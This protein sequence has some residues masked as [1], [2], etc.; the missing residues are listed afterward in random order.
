MI[1]GL[2]DAD[3][4]A[5]GAAG[6]AGAGGDGGAAGGEGGAGAGE[7]GKGTKGDAPTTPTR[8]AFLQKLDKIRESD[9]GAIAGGK[10][11]DDDDEEEL[12]EDAVIDQDEELDDDDDAGAGA[13]DDDDAPEPI[14]READG[15]EWIVDE[16]GQDGHWELDGTA[17]EGAPPKDW[18]PTPAPKVAAGKEG[19]DGKGGKDD[20]GKKVKPLV[21]K[22]PGR[23][24][25]D[26]DVPLP[27]DRAALAKLG[28]D[29]EHA[30]QR[31]AQLLNGYRRGAAVEKDRRE[32]EAER[33]QFDATMAEWKEAPRDFMLDHVKA[34]E[35]VG[36][37][38]ALL[39]RMDEDAYATLMD[40]VDKW[41]DDP[42]QRRLAAAQEREAASDRKEKRSTAQ[43]QLKAR[44]EYTNALHEQVT[45]LV[46]DDWNEDDANEFYDFVAVALQ[47]WA[48][49]QPK[50][51]RLD[52]TKVP[53]LLDELGVLRRFELERPDGD[54]DA[55]HAQSRT[56][57]TRSRP[58]RSSSRTPGKTP[59]K[60]DR[61]QLARQTAK[62]LQDRHDRR[63]AAA[64]TPA[65]AGAAAASAGMPKGQ[66]FKDRMKAIRKKLGV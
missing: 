41:Q 66:S 64:A 32:F 61:E 1:D 14:V 9:T 18:K 3:G 22:L 8:S 60:A 65:G 7:G 13:D 58:N 36:I 35:H 20:A 57:T 5:A 30:K 42:S 19:K 26:K 54:A 51:T 47:R 11:D 28:I 55:E 12:D 50:G 31:M 29:P 53:E 52:P 63:R 37:V 23:S 21:F 62:D 33:A 39:A 4:G 6:S 38:K 48:T 46:P 16:D 10:E 2:D 56:R 17:V 15:A 40:E 49:K 44:T 27:I 24:D 43:A 25:G 45:S 34:E 59:G